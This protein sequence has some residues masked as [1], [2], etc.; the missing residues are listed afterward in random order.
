M[1][2]SNPG[3]TLETRYRCPDC[4]YERTLI[5]GTQWQHVDELHRYR[6]DIARG[7]YG[8]QAQ[9][10][11]IKRPEGTLTISTALFTCRRCG[12]IKTAERLLLEYR[13][14]RL[15]ETPVRCTTCHVPCKL[16]TSPP[17]NLPCPA[18]GKTCIAIDFPPEKH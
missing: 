12:L 7:K 17:P 9:K 2:I 16:L 11:L 4:H 14:I 10:W 5:H 6:R 13:D 15:W 3:M 18:C 8:D 1:L